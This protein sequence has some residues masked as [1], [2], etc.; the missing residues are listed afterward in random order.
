MR[1]R[2]AMVS[3]A[4]VTAALAVLFTGTVEAK[5]GGSSG[6]GKH[7]DETA[8]ATDWDDLDRRADSSGDGQVAVIVTLRS[9][10]DPNTIDKRGPGSDDGFTRQRDS[11]VDHFH[12]KKLR[13]L[14]TMDGAPFVTMMV[15]RNDIEVL[16]SS[17][18][19]EDVVVDG[20]ADIDGTTA[21]GSANG[22]QL[23]SQWDNGVINSTWTN[24]NNYRGTGQAVAIIDSGVDRYNPYLA[25]RVINEACFA[26]NT[27]GTGA[28]NNGLTSQY[29][30]GYS[31]VVGAAAPC[32]Y[33]TNCSHGT[34]V[35]HTAAGAYGVAQG[36]SIVAI[37][38]SHKEYSAKAGGYVPLFGNGDLA[39]AL[40]YV[41]VVLPK[42][43][44]VVA[45]VNMS[46]GGQVF[47]TTCDNQVPVVT[48][49]ITHLRTTLH[50]PTVI[51]SG[52]DNAATGVSWPACI[53]TAVVV[54]NSTLTAAS[55]GVD[56]VFGNVNIG[57]NSS[58]LVDVL[59]PG[60]DICSAV[61]VGLDTDGTA[62]GWQCGWIG[63][64]MAAPHVAGAMAVLAQ[65]RPT[66]TVEQRLAA[67]QKAGATGGVSVTDSR[68]G[69]T[70]TRINVAN[71]VYYNI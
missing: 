65:K 47:T 6:S 54:G 24:A 51:S 32:T 39:W 49:Y 21:F 41:D 9:P 7:S 67:L 33:S 59:A 57:S 40:W 26:T 38:A 71:A 15:D 60:T 28:C 37:R 14:R 18:E 17:P 68:N 31:G 34:H 4:A 53:S 5:D 2:R 42:A 50:I 43:G 8:H 23:P 46:I 69:V 27:D 11:L 3:I 44:I 35:A 1:T 22:Q 19:V 56:A 66:S 10:T 63:T 16:R 48:S 55:G 61:P 64:S 30:T 58:S 29:G 13:G 20:V 12:G 45:A 52:N 62:D 36:A 70:R 25:G